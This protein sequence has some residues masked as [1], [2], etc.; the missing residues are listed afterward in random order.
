MSPEVFSQVLPRW[1]LRIELPRKLHAEFI[2][3]N[4]YEEMMR[5]EDDPEGTYRHSKTC[6]RAV[7]LSCRMESVRGNASP[8][9]VQTLIH[10]R[11]GKRVIIPCRSS[12][13]KS[14]WVSFLA[15]MS[16]D[17]GMW[18]SSPGPVAIYDEQRLVFPAHDVSPSM[19]LVCPKPTE[20]CKDS[21]CFWRRSFMTLANPPLRIRLERFRTSLLTPPPGY[22]RHLELL[23]K[24]NQAS[25]MLWN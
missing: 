3:L 14:Y 2:F 5:V 18:L 10:K 11:R 21:V 20:P 22:R 9:R 4:Q 1:N 8:F 7:Y 13:P 6:A 16:L 23:T 25:L 12:W 17:I 15:I 24:K 19:H